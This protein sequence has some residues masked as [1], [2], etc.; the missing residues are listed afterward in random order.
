MTK[1][2]YIKLVTQTAATLISGDPNAWTATDTMVKPAIRGATE[3]IQAAINSANS[4]P[5]LEDEPIEIEEL[6]F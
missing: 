4:V 6:P 5:G 3:I 1:T 2:E